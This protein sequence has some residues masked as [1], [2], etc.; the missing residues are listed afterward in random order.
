MNKLKK[1]FSDLRKSTP[2]HI[3]WLLLAAAFVVVLILLTLLLTRKDTEPVTTTE[4]EVALE[5]YVTPDTVDWAN[6]MVG[7]PLR[8]LCNCRQMH[9]CA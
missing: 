3:Q 6:V 7:E 8:Q 4:D 5:L 1:Q 2:K 9:P